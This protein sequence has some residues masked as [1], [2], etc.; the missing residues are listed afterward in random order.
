MFSASSFAS[1]PDA[2]VVK[3]RL[4]ISGF[5]GEKAMVVGDPQTNLRYQWLSMEIDY[6]MDDTLGLGVGYWKQAYLDD[7]VYQEDPLERFL[8]ALMGMSFLPKYIDNIADFHLRSQFASEDDGGA[9]DAAWI[10]GVGLVTGWDQLGYTRQY[11][12]PEFGVGISKRVI[13]EWLIFRINLVAGL[14]GG[15]E[16][17]LKPMDNF[18]ITFG[19]DALLNLKIIF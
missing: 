12:I 7:L 19:N 10:V 15:V 13:D 6:G 17:G 18:E 4:E 11:L 5:S 16:F 2:N 8:L 9:Y 1:I 3:D 14:P